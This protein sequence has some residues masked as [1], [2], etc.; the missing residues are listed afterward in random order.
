MARLPRIL[1]DY[2]VDTDQSVRKLSESHLL[3]EAQT[4]LELMN[5]SSCDAMWADEYP[6]PRLKRSL[7]RY[8]DRLV[9]KGVEPRLDFE[10]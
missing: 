1:N 4:C 7:E 9:A 3:F 6:D 10:M 2:L 5:E 8:I